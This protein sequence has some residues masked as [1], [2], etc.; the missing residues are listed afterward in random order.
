MKNKLYALTAIVTA[1]A[2]AACGGAQRPGELDPEGIG[3]VRLGMQIGEVPPQAEGWY[4]A[5]EVEHTDESFDDLEYETIPAFDTYLFQLN[6]E[7]MFR[8]SLRGGATTI[9]YLAAVSPRIGY[10]GIHPGMTVADALAAGA[11]CHAMGEFGGYGGYFSAYLA[12]DDTGVSFLFDYLNGHGFTQRFGQ[13]LA[14][15]GLIEN[16]I[17]DVTGD[18]F[19][20]DAVIESISINR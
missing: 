19:R 20:P 11:R 8:T 4:D 10:K 18:D 5:I 1:F 2:L 9:D 14:E 15:R 17:L 16:E 13:K 6:G 7:T 3:P 12:I